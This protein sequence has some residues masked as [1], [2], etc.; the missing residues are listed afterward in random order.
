VRE[1]FVAALRKAMQG[2]F[3]PRFYETE[4]GYQGALIAQLTIHLDI[5]AL[6]GNPIIEQE[7]QKTLPRH[8]ITIRPDIIIHIPSRPNSDDDRSFGNFVA[9]EI[10]R[11]ATDVEAKLDYDSLALLAHRLAYPL[12]IFINIDS[13]DDHRRSCPP[14]IT[15]QTISVSVR[16][17]DGVPVIRGSDG[18]LTNFTY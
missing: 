6:N 7:Y 10:K 13:D 12:T 18:L 16:L 8:G 1:M 17:E 4:R 3:D 9:I 2:I 14:E 5:A 11:G 15:E